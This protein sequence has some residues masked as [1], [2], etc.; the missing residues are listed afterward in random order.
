MPPEHHMCF[1]MSLG[2]THH[3]MV[4]EAAPRAARVAHEVADDGDVKDVDVPLPAPYDQI[5][6]T[7]SLLA[8]HFDEAV[9]LVFPPGNVADDQQ[10]DGVLG[11][12]K[13]RCSF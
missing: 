3:A 5:G 10:P 2:A 11:E 12:T 9:D 13:P 8:R 4:C 6:Q 7:V 1:Q